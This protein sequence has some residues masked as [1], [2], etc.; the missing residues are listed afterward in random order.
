MDRIVVLAEAAARAS[1]RP[2]SP[3]GQR[4]SKRSVQ[5]PTV[6]GGERGRDPGHADG[7]LLER[8]DTSRRDCPSSVKVVMAVGHRGGSEI[9]RST[10][11]QGILW[12]GYLATGAVSSWTQ[13]AP[14]LC[15]AIVRI[16][17]FHDGPTLLP[18]RNPRPGVE[19]DRSTCSSRIA[20]LVASIDETPAPPMALI[21]AGRPVA[22]AVPEA[23]AE[24]LLAG[25]I[26]A[27]PRR[28]CAS[29]PGPLCL[30]WVAAPVRVGASIAAGARR[31]LGAYG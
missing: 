15:T 16:G 27:P 20:G 25:A 17:E 26:S 7:S 13:N 18:P 11:R 24:L 30:W 31:T 5:W 12:D 1:G 6:Q 4:A 19:V 29:P 3:P 9:Q 10:G 2:R 21:S 14:L 8:R 28:R 23:R 22:G